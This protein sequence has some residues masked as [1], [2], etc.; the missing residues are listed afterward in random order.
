MCVYISPV[1]GRVIP[2][3]VV[4]EDPEDMPNIKSILVKVCLPQGS[5]STKSENN[6]IRIFVSNDPSYSADV[7][8]PFVFAT[9][10][11]VSS[12]LTQLSMR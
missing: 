3:V 4:F 9:V 10:I 12:N 11:I 5:D 7:Q 8:E 1:H 2:Q 6:D